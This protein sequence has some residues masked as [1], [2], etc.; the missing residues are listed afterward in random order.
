MYATQGSITTGTAA[1]RA[2][3]S[4]TIPA[5]AAWRLRGIG[6]LRIVFGLVWAVDAWFKWQPAF[7]NGLHDYLTEPLEGQP[8]AVQSWINFWM[9]T[10]HIDPTLFA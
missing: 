4:A 10:V 8:P 9:T 5:L 6:L 7:I 3:G 1:A 2:A